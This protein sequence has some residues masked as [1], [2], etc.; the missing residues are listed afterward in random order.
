[1]FEDRVKYLCVATLALLAIRS[2]SAHH[3]FAAEFD[4]DRT[5]MIEGEVI[6]VL[7]VNP[8]ARFF[9]AVTDEAGNEVI[10][11]AQSRSLSALT[12]VGWTP[13]T[14]KVG[15]RVSMHGNLGKGDARKL[16]ISEVT[17]PDGRVIRPVAEEA[18]R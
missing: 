13:D 14:I 5:G 12:R 16:W 2:V 1:M 4:Y 8:H 17:L 15:D 18:G 11:D 3:S 6:E 9:V 10:W 7:F